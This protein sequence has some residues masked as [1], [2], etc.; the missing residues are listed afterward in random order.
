MVK[1][2]RYNGGFNQSEGSEVQLLE[3]F[4]IAVALSVDAMVVALCWGAVQPKIKVSHVLKF[5]VVFG[6]FQALMPA[7]GWL[8]GG[9]LYSLV[10]AWDHWVAFG[11]LFF[12]AVSM[13]REA[14]EKDEDNGQCECRSMGSDIAWGKLAML[15]VATSLDALAVGFSFAMVSMPIAGPAAII[16][17]VCALLTALAMLAAG[18]LSEKAARHS[19]KLSLLGAA[20][21]LLIG[22]RILFEHGVF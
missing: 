18:V 12:V 11:L 10:N 6:A 9:A 13:I 19:K 7:L 3:I 22:L 16:G 1:S 21:L 20:V 15:A 4:G 5:S 2:D 17:I 8:A 14:F